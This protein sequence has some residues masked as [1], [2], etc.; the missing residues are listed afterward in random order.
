[1]K[2]YTDD[3][4]CTEIT[5]IGSRCS[6]KANDTGLCPQHFDRQLIR[7][8]GKPAAE[9]THSVTIK[10]LGETAEVKLSQGSVFPEYVDFIRAVPG[11][12]FDWD[13]KTWIIPADWAELLIEGF[14][15]KGVD[16]H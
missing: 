16:V 14:R 13:R 10:T 7:M 6:R 4:C 15:R 8:L 3:E 5:A 2:T 12:Y 1:M 11:R 9:K